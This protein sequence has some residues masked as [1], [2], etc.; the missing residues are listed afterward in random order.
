MINK[1]L[2]IAGSDSGGGAGIQADLKTFS[3]LGI[4]GASVITAVTAQN[5]L[6]VSGIFDLPAEFVALQI[7]AVLTDIGADAA[8]TGMLS[9]PKIIEIVSQKVE[10]YGLKRLV[11]DP[12]M[13]SSSA[14]R[15]ITTESQEV[16][17]KRLLPLG[18]LV[19]PNLDEAIVIARFEVKTVQDM[20]RAAE[21]IKRLGVAN[22][23]VKGG[24]LIG[25]AVDILF[26]GREFSY[27]RSERLPIENTHGTGCT[28]SAAITA[29][30]AKGNDLKSAVKAAKDYTTNALRY[31]YR[32]GNGSIPLNHFYQIREN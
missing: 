29:F 17:I 21:K 31:A 25:D 3:A 2:T 30:L 10:E 27:Y 12:V 15:L 28:L 13:V 24:H 23:L 1:A 8:K 5:T 14:H 7:D 22:V 6:G 26:D 19:T 9:N 20:E 32:V 4:H 11:I 16:L 18:Y